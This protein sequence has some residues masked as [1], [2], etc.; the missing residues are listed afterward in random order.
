MSS[1]PTSLGRAA[2]ALC[3]PVLLLTS[4]VLLMTQATP[5]YRYAF[6]KYRVA[7]TTGLTEAELVRATKEMVAYFFQPTEPLAIEV[8][9]GGLRRPLLNQREIDHLRDVKQ[10]FGL[11]Q[12]SQLAS[13]VAYLVVTGALL[14]WAGTRGRWAVASGLLWGGGLTLGLLTAA[15]LG[16][17]LDFD[18]LF[19]RFH[20]ISF[21]NDLWQ[22]DPSRDYLIM[23]FPLG[24][25][26]EAALLVVALTAAL[27]ALTWGLGW[28]LLGRVPP[29]AAA[30]ARET[31]ARG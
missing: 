3:L 27:A 29:Q 8:N 4:S 14:A 21:S 11:V 31:A 6:A 7:E 9:L 12:V 25:W 10:I 22:L 20:L 24:F 16:V 18:G 28:F 17:L 5:F 1:L 23:M 15:A 19:V 13:G 26:L 30:P 2:I